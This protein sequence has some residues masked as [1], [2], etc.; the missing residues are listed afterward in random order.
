MVGN[1]AFPPLSHDT[2]RRAFGQLLPSDWMAVEIQGTAVA[3]DGGWVVSI[4][5]RKLADC[6]SAMLV[7][8]NYIIEKLNRPV[9]I[10]LLIPES[11]KHRSLREMLRHEDRKA[12]ATR[13]LGSLAYTAFGVALGVSARFFI[14][15]G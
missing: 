6:V 1:D 12:R 7:L 9:A 5:G 3:I 4:K 8:N 10:D 14:F 2:Q 11:D 13:I 15:G